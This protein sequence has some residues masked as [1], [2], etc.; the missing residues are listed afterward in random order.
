MMNPVR[1]LTRKRPAVQPPPEAF[2]VELPK[3]LLRYAHP[4][5]RW[6]AGNHVEILRNGDQTFPAQLAAIAAAQRSISLEIYIFEDDVIGRQFINAL[7]ERAKAGVKVRLLYDAVGS[8][9]LPDEQIER[10]HSAGVETV[11]FHPVAPWRRRFNWRLRD[12]RKILV[13]DDDIAFVGGLNIGKEYASKAQG[14]DGWHDMHC[15]LRGPIVADLSRTF[16]RNWI[17]NGGRDYPAAPR[18]E[19]LPPTEGASFV[20]MIDNALAKRRRPI[21]QAYLA[22]LYA[23]Q[24]QV[25]LKNAY[26]LPDRKLRRAISRAVKRGVE[27]AVIVPGNSDV[28]L[29]EWAGNYVHRWLTRAG[30][31]ILRWPNVMMH[32]K[33]AVVDGVWSTIGSYNLDSRSLRYNLEITVEMLDEEI[34]GEMVRQFKRDALTCEPYDETVW[35]ALPWWKKARAWVAYQFRRWL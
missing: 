18:A 28:R 32:A 3:E 31:R 10:M 5:S 25:L 11:E 7:C 29:V 21:R 16:R 12:H 15:S 30:V 13:V 23:A 2:A 8:F 4:R 24:K 35:K 1:L 33:T 17:A 14:G 26:F 34:G 22:V 19:T 9:S 6:R 20:R 27:V